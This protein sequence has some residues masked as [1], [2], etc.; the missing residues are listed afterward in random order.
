[1]AQ[2]DCVCQGSFSTHFRI[3]LDLSRPFEG[4][5]IEETIWSRG[6]E[7]AIIFVI[8][9]YEGRS[10]G[11]TGLNKVLRPSGKRRGLTCVVRDEDSYGACE[12]PLNS[13]EESRTGGRRHRLQ[14]K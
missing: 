2:H 3:E 9:G 4:L 7:D 11:C 8:P 12:E 5:R 10:M 14:M 13:A 1:M 6:F